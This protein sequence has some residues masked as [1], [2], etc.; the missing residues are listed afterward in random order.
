VNEIRSNE[1]RFLITGGLSTLATRLANPQV[2]LPWV[3]GILGGPL[4][5]FGLLIPSIRL[6]G[7]IAQLTI[8]PTL[9]ALSIRKWTYVIASMVV[10]AALVLI[11]AATLNLGIVAA[12]AVFFAS[13]LLLG[14]CM[15]IMALTSQETMAKTIERERIGPLL[16]MQVSIGGFLTLLLVSIFIFV[17]PDTGSTRQHLTLIFLSAAVWIG[18]GLSFALIKEPPSVTQGKRSIWAETHRGWVLYRTTP[19]FSRFFVT[20]ALFLSVGLAT[21]FYAIN[22]ASE[23][24]NVNH[25]LSLFVLAAGVANIISRP[26]WGPLLSRNPCRVLVWS[27][28]LAAVA[29]IVAILNSVSDDLPNLP[30][31]MLVFALLDLAVQGMTQSSRTY[32]AL[33]A[34]AHNRPLFLAINNAML[35]ILAIVISG[36]IGVIAH[37]THIF[38]S[39][40]LLIAFAL[41]ASA[42]A[43][44]LKPPLIRSDG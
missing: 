26:I 34:P 24:Q 6:G 5:L 41:L 42:S 31:Y 10:S 32:L 12:V 7:L 43:V 44:N 39:H 36:L 37:S 27:G 33:M 35:G 17:Y 25:S 11:C 40:S 29:G 21:P 9:L 22:A 18:A 20:R 19:W 8:V 28:I 1:T 3:Y 16:A 14:A 13:T 38:W 2:V 4:V 23:Y 30:M 15:G